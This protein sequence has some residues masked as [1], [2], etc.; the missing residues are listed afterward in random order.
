MSLE[1][2]GSHLQSA[3][4]SASR[5]M[6]PL[7]CS[8]GDFHHWRRGTIPPPPGPLLHGHLR[9]LGRPDPAQAGPGS[10]QPPA[11]RPAA[12]T[13]RRGRGR[14][15][16]SDRGAVCRT[17]A[18]RD[19][20][21]LPP[22]PGGRALAAPAGRDLLRQRWTTRTRRATPPWANT[23]TP[24]IAIA[25][26]R[27]TACST[28]PRRRRPSLRSSSGLGQAGLNRRRGRAAWA[29]IVLEKPIG[30]DLESARELNRTGQP[31]LRRDGRLSHR[32]LPGQGDGAEPAGL[33]LRQ[34]HL[35]A[36][37]EPEVRRSRADHRGRVD[38]RRGPRRLLRGSR[39]HARHGAEPHVPAAL[40]G[41]HGAP[42]LAGRRRDPRREG[43]GA[44]GAAPGEPV[45]RVR[46]LDRARPVRGRA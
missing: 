16:R 20:E 39:H 44:A 28:W 3:T 7:R 11:R 5:S 17:A 26:P 30:R 21:P 9:R 45:E 31:G 2:S 1:R 25:A 19:R 27:A 32:S 33:P 41:R 29:R 38:R 46:R 6:N 10:V 18:G 23:S 12:R 8:H 42:G 36:A 34:R 22:G 14:E 35:R 24:S 37:V 43:Q 13:V 4:L 15:A 40:P